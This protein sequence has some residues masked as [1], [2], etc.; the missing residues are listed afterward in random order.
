MFVTRAYSLM[1]HY[2]KNNILIYTI[3]VDFSLISLYM[4]LE[5]LYCLYTVEEK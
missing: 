1:I 4:W 2:E 5:C 3:S